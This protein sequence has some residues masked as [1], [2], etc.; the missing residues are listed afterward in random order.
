LEEDYISVYDDSDDNSTMYDDDDEEEGGA[1]AANVLPITEEINIGNTIDNSNSMVVIVEKNGDSYLVDKDTKQRKC[2][3][4]VH[5]KLM[6][7]WL[8]YHASNDRNLC[9]ECHYNHS[10]SNNK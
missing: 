10:C 6:K 1:P 2:N 4:T 7:A 5:F 3:H 8:E 9:I